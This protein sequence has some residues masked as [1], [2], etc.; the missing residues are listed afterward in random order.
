MRKE[1]NP[2]MAIGLVAVIVLVIAFFVWKTV[3]RNPSSGPAISAA[4]AGLGKPVQ[5]STPPAN[6]VQHATNPH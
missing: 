2:Q 5:P 6:Q 3:M 4:E 1:I